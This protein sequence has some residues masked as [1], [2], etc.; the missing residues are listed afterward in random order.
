MAVLK[1]KN[2]GSESADGFP[3]GSLVNTPTPR[4]S[5]EDKFINRVHNFQAYFQAY[6]ADGRCSLYVDDHGSHKNLQAVQFY[7][8]K[9]KTELTKKVF[10]V[11]AYKVF[12]F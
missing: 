6:K 10:R 9:R 1:G 2:Y 11:I 12:R 8:K 4:W 5:G 7:K 3:N